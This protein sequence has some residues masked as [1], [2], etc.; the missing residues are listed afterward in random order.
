MNVTDSDDAV[1]NGAGG[2]V[3]G[4]D[5]D[6][7]Q[8]GGTVKGGCANQGDSAYES[9]DEGFSDHGGGRVSCG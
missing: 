1:S 5:G 3:H 6:G 8:L 9:S 2:K 4:T 7:D